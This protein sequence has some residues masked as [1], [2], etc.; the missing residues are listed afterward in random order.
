MANQ[1]LSCM[2]VLHTI[3]TVQSVHEASHPSTNM[4]HT[5]IVQSQLLVR[6]EIHRARI[7][8][9]R[10]AN[11]QIRLTLGPSSSL[12][13]GGLATDQENICLKL[14]GFRN[15]FGEHVMQGS[16]IKTI[17][18]FMFTSEPRE[19]LIPSLISM[20]HQTPNRD[21]KDLGQEIDKFP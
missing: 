15:N 9:M 3:N 2:K 14:F 10:Q 8:P 20:S 21:C 18:E 7:A 16:T 12:V 4:V 17:K 6:L 1:A 19:V 11:A 5:E 13:V